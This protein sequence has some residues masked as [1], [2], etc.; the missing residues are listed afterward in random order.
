MILSSIYALLC[1]AID[2]KRIK[3]ALLLGFTIL[4]AIILA[5]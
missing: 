3:L 1:Y 5:Y 4:S 2:I